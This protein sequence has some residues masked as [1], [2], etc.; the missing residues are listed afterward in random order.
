MSKAKVITPKLAKPEFGK[1]ISHPNA[2]GS[3]VYNTE[4]GRPM[5]VPAP[6]ETVNEAAGSIGTTG[7]VPQVKSGVVV[8]K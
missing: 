3:I 7:K 5:I 4:F 1:G 6:C 2:P 8:Q